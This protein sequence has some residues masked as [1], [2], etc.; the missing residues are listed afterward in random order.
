[1]TKKQTLDKIKKLLNTKK[2]YIIK[3]AERL[4]NTG[5]IDLESWEND[6][7]LPRAV[8]YVA[9]ENVNDDISLC[10]FDVKA[11]AKNLEKF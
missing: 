3:E 5:A 7:L 11:T 2:V 1:M 8:L 9:I 4:L 10:P 6:Y